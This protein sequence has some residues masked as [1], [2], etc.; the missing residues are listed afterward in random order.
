MMAAIN[1]NQPI[2]ELLLA[3]DVDQSTQDAE[4]NTALHHA[5]FSGSPEFPIRLMQSRMFNY[6][7]FETI[8]KALE[9]PVLL[10][11]KYA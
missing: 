4:G 5:V 2:F 10:A 7:A 3:C 1:R 9:T 6:E 11:V 8:N